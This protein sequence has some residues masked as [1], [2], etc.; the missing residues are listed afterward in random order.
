MWFVFHSRPGSVIADYT[1]NATSNTLEFE[2]ANT[3]VLE[4]LRR[5]GLSLAN[6]AFTLSGKGTQCL[7]K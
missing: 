3:Q 1:I 6:D 2:A 7:I 4:S 5:Q